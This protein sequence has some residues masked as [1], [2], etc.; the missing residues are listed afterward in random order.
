MERNRLLTTPEH[1]GSGNN[2]GQPHSWA[3]ARGPSRAS[4]STRGRIAARPGNWSRDFQSG[5]EF[6]ENP[7]SKLISSTSPKETIQRQ[8]HHRRSFSR[9]SIFLI[10][11]LSRPF[12]GV[13]TCLQGGNFL[14]SNSC[15]PVGCIRSSL[16]W[17]VKGGR[18]DSF[19]PQL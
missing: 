3:S 16:A 11:V 6:K 19:S 7:N 17:V 4:L 10:P 1:L 13:P 15:R 5:R 14:H 12:T 9:Y 8:A 2:S 18:C